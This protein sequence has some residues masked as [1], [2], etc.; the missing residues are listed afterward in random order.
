M[1]ID[2]KDVR[3][4]V[5]YFLLVSEVEKGGVQVKI[6]KDHVDLCQMQYQNRIT[7]QSGPLLEEVR[8]QKANQKSSSEQIS[9]KS[10]CLRWRSPTET[11]KHSIGWFDAVLQLSSS[12]HCYSSSTTNLFSH[13]TV[14][15]SMAILAAQN[16]KE[17]CNARFVALWSLTV[18]PKGNWHRAQGKKFLYSVATFISYLQDTNR[19][20]EFPIPSYLT[21]QTLSSLLIAKGRDHGGAMGFQ[22]IHDATFQSM[23]QWVRVRVSVLKTLRKHHSEDK[24]KG[25]HLCF[26]HHGPPFLLV[27]TVADPTLGVECQRLVIFKVGKIM[28]SQGGNLHS[29]V[30]V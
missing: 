2:H 4:I 15:T 18:Q 6:Y 3:G 7:H 10:S 26:C 14:H 16:T 11:W 23:C 17:K 13:W 19:E 27:S 30:L 12:T 20:R 21:Q 22:I 29:I 24:E 8:S 5:R 28:G 25:W 1:L 9:R